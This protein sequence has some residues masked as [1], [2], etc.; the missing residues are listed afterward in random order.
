V[1]GP[2]GP[3]AISAGTCPNPTYALNGS[4][5]GGALVVLAGALLGARAYAA[6]AGRLPH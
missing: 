5:S 2:D 3:I 6:V 4:G 1:L